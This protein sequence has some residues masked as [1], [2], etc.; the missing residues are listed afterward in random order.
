MIEPKVGTVLR[1]DFLWKDDADKGKD[2][3]KDRPCAIIMAVESKDD[4][5]HKVL[6]CP[7][8]HSPPTNGQSAVELPVKVSRHLGLDDDQSWIKTDQLNSMTWEKNRPPVGVTPITKGQWSYGE[9]PHELG[10]QAFDQVR[11]NAQSKSLGSVDR[12]SEKPR[13]SARDMM[14][15]Q[16]E[17]SQTKKR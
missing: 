5:T 17:Q 1:Y 6:V 3:G 7:I 11:S 8:T 4:G 14:R 2:Q 9:L 13:R 15:E 10:R 16:R 12:D